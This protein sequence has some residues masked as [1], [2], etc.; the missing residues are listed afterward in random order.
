MKL[1]IAGL[2][3]FQLVLCP[4]AASGGL[5]VVG[6]AADGLVDVNGVGDTEPIPAI[7]PGTG[8]NNSRGQAA[9]FFFELPSFASRDAIAGVDL[10][11]H[12]LGIDGSVPNFNLDLYGI[13]ARAVAQIQASDYYDGSGF[14]AT[15]TLIQDDIVI[16]S[17]AVGPLELNVEGRE[18]LFDFVTSLYSADGSPIDRFAVFRL[19]PDIDLPPG[20]SPI[21][22]YLVAAAEHA[23]DLRPRMEIS[24]VPEPGTLTTWLVLCAVAG[25]CSRSKAC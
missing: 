20:S 17:T 9:I 24:A 15:S 23:E 2:L 19:N 25:L 14:D 21:R 3:V 7:R 13:G 8:G 16:P 12:Y 10:E 1:R 4:L 5:I 22:G 11:V 6:D 18:S